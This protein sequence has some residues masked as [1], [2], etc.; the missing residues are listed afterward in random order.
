[1]CDK[2]LGLKNQSETVASKARAGGT[3]R[4]PLFVH[5]TWPLVSNSKSPFQIDA[6]AKP[7][8]ERDL[9]IRHLGMSVFQL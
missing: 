2:R 4:Y 3:Y 1:M 8:A 7:L 5:F 6:G 9:E